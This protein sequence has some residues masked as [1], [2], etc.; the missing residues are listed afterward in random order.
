MSDKNF[1]DFIEIGTCDG[2]TLIQKANGKQK[3]ISIDPMGHYLDN[4]P[5]KENCIKICVAIS[6]KEEEVDIFYITEDDIKKHNL[7][8]WVRGSN[9]LYQPHPFVL[10]LLSAESEQH[11]IPEPLDPDKVITKGKIK[12]RRLKSIIDE[13]KI[14]GIKILKIDAEKTDDII[15]LDYFDCCKN[16]GYPYPFLIQYEHILLPPRRRHHLLI[17]AIEAGYTVQKE[18]LENTTLVRK[19]L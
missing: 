19:K 2:D 9:S 14:D 6:N 17:T 16:E 3:G 4:L 18:H 11:P 7:P 10:T 1:Y 13:Y 5:D 15:L 8:S 12:T